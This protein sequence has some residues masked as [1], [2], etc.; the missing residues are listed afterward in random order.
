M[1]ILPVQI[2][3]NNLLKQY[4]AFAVKSYLQMNI[5]IYNYYQIDLLNFVNK[6]ISIIV[7]FIIGFNTHIFKCCNFTFYSLSFYLNNLF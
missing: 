1:Y 7:Y 2:K 5:I 4:S 3:I 6:V